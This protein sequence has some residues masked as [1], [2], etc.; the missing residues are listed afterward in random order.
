MVVLAWIA[1]DVHYYNLQLLDEGPITP[2][3]CGTIRRHLRCNNVKSGGPHL[4]LNIIQAISWLELDGNV[5][6]TVGKC[7]LQ[8]G[9]QIMNNV[10]GV[11]MYSYELSD[12]LDI[13]KWIRNDW[14]DVKW[15]C[16]GWKSTGSRENRPA[17][18][19]VEA[20][21]FEIFIESYFILF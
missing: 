18:W 2:A 16:W 19:L 8:E 6:V 3:T 20:S 1:N 12:F 5:G 14:D 15:N 13:S 4:F 9:R 11:P 10:W 17:I 21:W 7:R